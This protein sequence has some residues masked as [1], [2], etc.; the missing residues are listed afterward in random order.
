MAARQRMEVDSEMRTP[1][2]PSDRVIQRRNSRTD[3]VVGTN[4]GSV[5]PGRNRWRTDVSEAELLVNDGPR[6]RCVELSLA[7]LLAI[8]VCGG[9]AMIIT[10]MA[11]PVICDL[12]LRQWYS[13][14]FV[15]LSIFTMFLGGYVFKIGVGAW[16]WTRRY[17]A[18]CDVDWHAAWQ[19]ESAS[20][21]QS[22]AGVKDWSAP[23]HFVVVTNYKE[24]IEVLRL[25]AY[26]LM[27]QRS[28]GTAGSFCRGQITLVLAM[29][30]REGQAAREKAN[31]LHAEF[32]PFFRDVVATYHP[33]DLPG[34]I[35]GKASNY[36]WAVHELE[37]YIRGQV[38]KA[39]GL[40]G[41]DCLIHVA[42]ADSLYDPNYFP[43]VN[44]LFCTKSNRYEMVFQPCMVPIC[45]IWELS[46]MPRQI[47]C[48]ISAQEMMSAVGWTLLEY[49]IP[50]ST[51]GFPLKTLRLVGGTGHAG[52]AQDGDVIA[53]D[54]HLY[55][56]AFFAL[57]GKLQT[58]PIYLP[59][60]NFAVGG[61]SSSVWRNLQ[62]RFV[63]A[64]RHMFGVSE[65]IY[66]WALVFRS[67][68]RRRRYG[69]DGRACF[70]AFCLGMKLLKIHFVAYVGLWMLLGGLLLTVL[71]LDSLLC[72]NGPSAVHAQWVCDSKYEGITD[73]M[74]LYVFSAVS[75]I[76]L[77]GGLFINAAFVRM[78]RSTLHTT[79]NIGDPAG[80][81][82]GPSFWHAASRSRRPSDEQVC[83][84][85]CGE[86][87]ANA[88]RPMEVGGGY[89]WFG[90][91]LQLFI[92]FLVLGPL[93][94]FFYGTLPAIV[95]LG[96]F[97]C[98]GHRLEY[99]TAHGAGASN[100]APS[101][102][103][104]TATNGAA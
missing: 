64:K 28:P 88:R 32:E 24:P 11:M 6:S 29:E 78:L 16:I 17:R 1:L 97:I 76:G 12:D 54:H 55:V 46:A 85:Q 71:K 5:G 69:M 39:A 100:D 15:A 52:D 26:T 18:V 82:M 58:Q 93:A 57:R 83:G 22:N 2:S 66:F 94:S 50:F 23:Q 104:T 34:D 63:Q 43:N 67:C 9:T 20:C 102:G 103:A 74:G 90:V 89:P 49:Q 19:K 77:V 31:T 99:V 10:G 59:C 27:A 25:L 36:K 91:H 3:S 61:S 14:L 41:E 4:G 73:S 95:S 60:L 81:F 68:C 33:P 96:Q 87:H 42:D 45:N 35:K 40:Q 51:Y 7:L 84:E 75:V 62:A 13:A 72:E 98:I 70:R 38:G 65:L 53:E 47:S 56:K 92:E 21:I 48:A 79:A 101:N 80:S 44:Y 30:E 37:T 86:E 8:V